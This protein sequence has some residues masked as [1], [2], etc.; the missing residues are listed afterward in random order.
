M[1]KCR[2]ERVYS[3]NLGFI[4]IY[5]YELQFNKADSVDAVAALL[6]LSLLI[7]NGFV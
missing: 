7:S 6:D 3:R 1:S 5:P 4:L 2:D